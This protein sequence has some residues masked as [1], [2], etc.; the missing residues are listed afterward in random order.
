L[1]ARSNAGTTIRMSTFSP[2]VVK[3]EIRNPKFEIPAPSISGRMFDFPILY[4]D[5]VLYFA[6]FEGGEALVKREPN[7]ELPEVIFSVN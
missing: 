1:E 3:S 5:I 2:R 7:C 4:L 6:T